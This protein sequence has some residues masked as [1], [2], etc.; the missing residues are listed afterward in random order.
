MI[1]LIRSGSWAL[2]PSLDTLRKICDLYAYNKKTSTSTVARKLFTAML[3]QKEYE[4]E[5]LPICSPAELPIYVGE[6]R[7][8]YPY[9]NFPRVK[10]TIHPCFVLGSI[11][12]YDTLKHS[13]DTL[14]FL[15]NDET[16]QRLVSDIIIMTAM[17][18]NL[19][20]LHGTWYDFPDRKIVSARPDPKPK[21]QLPPI[22]DAIK[23]GTAKQT[24]RYDE[25]DED[26]SEGYAIDEVRDTDN[27]RIHARR[28]RL[29][30]YMA[31]HNRRYQD[32]AEDEAQGEGSR[33][34]RKRNPSD[35][36]SEDTPTVRRSK[37]VQSGASGQSEV[38]S[39]KRKTSAPTRGRTPKHPARSSPALDDTAA[40]P[41]AARRSART[42]KAI[43]R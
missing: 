15:A 34:Q 25:E 30:A 38:A 31:K 9:R 16:R 14:N 41:P 27:P 3:P 33:A 29:Q 12:T 43:S 4:Y 22:D 39:T 7:H 37:R 42:R 10:T 19:S 35:S 18:V 36:P 32:E 1:Q 40:S 2:L 28:E 21:P 24:L 20:W 23:R 11:F 13:N 26:E 17:C 6:A 8:D 5:F